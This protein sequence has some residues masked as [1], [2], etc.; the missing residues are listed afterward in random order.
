MEL[1]AERIVRLLLCLTLVAGF[2]ARLS[3]ESRVQDGVVYRVATEEKVVALT[4]DDGPHPIFTPELLRVLGKYNVKATF[5]MIG[6]R[7]DAYPRTVE[8]VVKAGH[9]IANHTYDHPKNIELEP[10]NELVRELDMCERVIERFTG[11]RAQLFRP[12][13]GLV[14]GRVLSV[15]SEE[16]YTTI[17][18]TVCADHHDAPTPDLMARRVTDR[19][20]PGDIV[21]AH[22]GRFPTRWKDVTAAQLIIV[23]LRKQGYRF[24]TVPELLELGRREKERLGGGHAARIGNRV[25]RV[26]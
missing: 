23:S 24:V 7:M 21:L 3:P 5:F 22:D 26:S 15:V 18:W 12:P 14:D 25:G 16:G 4:F 6:R 13:K 1:K 20:R 11:K 9:V 8:A 2:S 17:L 19:V 10:R